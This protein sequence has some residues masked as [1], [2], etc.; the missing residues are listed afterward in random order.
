VGDQFLDRLRRN[1]GMHQQQL[2]EAADP[3]QRREVFH[4]IVGEGLVE[5]RCRRHRRVGAEEDRVAV[6]RRARDLRGGDRAVRAGLVLDDDALA[7]H[8]AEPLPD[9][10]S[11]QVAAAAGPERHDDGDRFVWVGLRVRG[12]SNKDSTKQRHRAEH[13]YHR[14]SSRQPIC[15]RLDLARASITDFRGFQARLSHSWSS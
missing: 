13:E 2:G 4:R 6:R 10:T 8:R 7:E 5:A 3:A 9:D 14:Q 15:R 12:R 11:D 1:V